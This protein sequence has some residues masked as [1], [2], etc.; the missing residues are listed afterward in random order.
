MDNVSR[1]A[2]LEGQLERCVQFQQVWPRRQVCLQQVVW[3]RRQV[4]L[5]QV[6]W[7]R[8]QAL[9]ANRIVGGP[10]ANLAAIRIVGGPLAN[11]AAIRIVG[12][13]SANLAANLS[14]LHYQTL[15]FSLE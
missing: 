15:S 4:C 2:V 6:V 5:Q 10:S 7:P 14:K 11:L 8:P 12:G 1:E 9:S 13:P 3:P